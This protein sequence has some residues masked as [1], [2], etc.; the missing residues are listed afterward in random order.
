MGAAVGVA[1][2]VLALVAVMAGRLQRCRGDGW[3]IAAKTRVWRGDLWIEAEIGSETRE[4]RPVLHLHRP[5]RQNTQDE[6]EM[7]TEIQMSFVVVLQ[8][9]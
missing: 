8:C 4:I 9:F 5:K 1:A 2:T 7:K 6:V 3:H